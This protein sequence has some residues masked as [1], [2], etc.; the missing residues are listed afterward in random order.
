MTSY[1]HVTEVRER[2][3]EICKCCNVWPM[4]VRLKLDLKMLHLC[5]SRYL[6]ARFGH[7][8]NARKYH[9]CI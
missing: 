5:L 8:G 6:R 1:R 4:F 7:L 3:V 2:M 9:I